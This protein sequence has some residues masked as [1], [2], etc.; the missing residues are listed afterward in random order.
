MEDQLDRAGP[1]THAPSFVDE[2]PIYKSSSM[3]DTSAHRTVPFPVLISVPL[4]VAIC[5]HLNAEL[6]TPRRQLDRYRV[7]RARQA[8]R[9]RGLWCVRVFHGAVR[10]CDADP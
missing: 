7:E 8:P 9:A 6:W 5:M 10:D 2:N 3:T 4:A 1:R